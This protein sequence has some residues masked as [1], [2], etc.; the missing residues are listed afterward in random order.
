[1]D[2]TENTSSMSNPAIA[3][4]STGEIK[5]LIVKEMEFIQSVITRMASNSFMLKGWLIGILSFILAFNKEAIFANSP[6]YAAVLVM[7]VLIFWYLGC[8]LPLHRAA[9]PGT[10]QGSNHQPVP[11]FIWRAI[12]RGPDAF[13][14]PGLHAF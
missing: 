7:P 8:F 1:M 6:Q 4:P 5:D 11:V 14:Q 9:I 12:A 3:P 2:L 10:L 13:V